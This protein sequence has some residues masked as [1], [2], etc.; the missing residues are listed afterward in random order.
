MATHGD[1]VRF[2]HPL[3]H[4]GLPPGPRLP[5]PVQSLLFA[6]R[7]VDFLRRCQRRY[8]DLFAINIAPVGRV[9]YAATPTALRT[10]TT[11]DPED[12]LGGEPKRVLEPIT[13]GESVLVL[14]GER[15]VRARKALT[16]PFQG[17]A[18]ARH[19]ELMTDATERAMRQWPRDRS[20]ALRPELRRLTLEILLSGPFGVDDP[21]TLSRFGEKLPS[22][23]DTNPLVLWYPPFHRDLGGFGPWSAFKRR[24]EELSD[25]LLKLVD[26]PGDVPSALRRE[27]DDVADPM[28]RTELR[29]HLLTLITTGHETSATALSWAILLLLRGRRVLDRLRDELASG[30]DTYL[31]A[32][33]RETLR[34]RPPAL[35]IARQLAVDVEVD[36]WTLPAGTKVTAS[37]A[38][39]Q[40]SSDVWPDPDAFRPERFIESSAK[41]YAWAPFGGGHRRC[42]GTGFAMLEMREVLRS[43]VTRA[44]LRAAGNEVEAITIRNALLVPA[45]GA[46]VVLEHLLDGRRHG[47]PARAGSRLGCARVPER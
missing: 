8:G 14:D 36:G 6:Y 38:L 40:L 34:V 45:K 5:L 37:P 41:P 21:A 17:E 26:G 4:G 2:H 7:P 10:L 28:S 32:V 44:E 22:V 33:V 27:R 19:A 3:R 15:H 39:I 46:Q 18:T 29:D 20:F 24:R 31:D 25:M 1:A 23:V 11:A 9:V 30:D 13:G 16:P 43:V 35:D 47:V 12:I 42:L